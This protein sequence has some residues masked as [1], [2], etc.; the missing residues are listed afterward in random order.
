MLEINGVKAEA[1]RPRRG[2]GGRAAPILAMVEELVKVLRSRPL[3]PAQ[4]LSL[5]NRIAGQ[6]FTPELKAIVT[7]L[8]AAAIDPEREGYEHRVRTATH[9]LLLTLEAM[10]KAQR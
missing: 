3:D 9:I 2:A 1:D 8:Q 10:Q 5:S 4:V 6:A 7:R